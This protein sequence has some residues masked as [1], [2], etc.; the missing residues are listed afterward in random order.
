MEKNP[1]VILH[2][3]LEKCAFMDP[4]FVLVKKLIHSFTFMESDSRN[5]PARG[6]W[7]NLH[8]NIA[9]ELK[10]IVRDIFNLHR[11]K[12]RSIEAENEAETETEIENDM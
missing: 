2:T 9:E 4:S 11:S 12:S 10:N 8:Q 6:S 5:L 7:L 3:I 1:A